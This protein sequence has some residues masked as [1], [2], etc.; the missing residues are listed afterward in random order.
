M[1]Y[2]K[3]VLYPLAGLDPSKAEQYFEIEELR[4]KL[5]LAG[6]EAARAY[7]DGEI[8]REAAAEWLQ[9]YNLYSHERAVQRTRFFDQYRSYVI[10][11]NRGKD[12]VSD[13]VERKGSGD[14][15]QRWAAFITL[16]TTPKT[17]SQLTKD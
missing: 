10:N 6:N 14:L 12:L 3:E 2:E 4:N 16:L 15:D 11:Y 1:K 7:L 17:A 13:Y 9:R 8:T 5:S